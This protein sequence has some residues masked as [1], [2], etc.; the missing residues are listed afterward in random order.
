MEESSIK[1]K[2]CF[3][4]FINSVEGERLAK[5]N[6][7]LGFIE[8]LA[9]KLRESFVFAWFLAS[10]TLTVVLMALIILSPMM[11]WPLLMNWPVPYCYFAYGMWIAF[12]MVAVV[13]AA[14]V[15]YARETRSE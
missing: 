10:S 3:S 1:V 11:L 4:F 9:L 14:L 5:A 7:L 15:G 8:S 13:L 6:R 12:W 2:Y